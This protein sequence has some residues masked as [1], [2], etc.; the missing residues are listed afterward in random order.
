MSGIRFSILSS[1]LCLVLVACT[2]SPTPTATPEMPTATRASP[3]ATPT[4]P[5]TPTQVPTVEASAV[6]GGSAL[7]VH[8]KDGDILVW[9][10]SSGQSETLFDAGDAI[11]LTMSDDGQVL[12]FLRR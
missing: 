12:A 9:E 11:A 3:T 8:I 6:S 7:V 10:E 4:L 2:P 5:L 1:L